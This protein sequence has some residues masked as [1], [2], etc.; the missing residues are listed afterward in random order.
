[1]CILSVYVYMC[2]YACTCT[3]IHTPYITHTH[4]HVYIYI[5]IFIFCSPLADLYV[6]MHVYTYMYMYIYIHTY[7]CMY[8]VCMQVCM[9]THT[10]ISIGTYMDT[11]IYKFMNTRTHTHIRLY[12]YIYIYICIYV[13]GPM[14]W[15]QP[16]SNNA[17]IAR[18]QR[19]ISHK[20]FATCTASSYRPCTNPICKYGR[21]SENSLLYYRSHTNSSYVAPTP[22]YEL[23]KAQLKEVFNFN[24]YSDLVLVAG[25]MAG[26]SI[27]LYQGRLS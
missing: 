7:A 13:Q 5:Y 11:Y 9:Y 16:E 8:F 26:A 4:I 14:Q 25:C 2:V 10:H 15:T 12:T 6:Y 27:G 18:C 17:L 24:T 22:K 19:L 3:Y 21:R 1:M 23:N 20:A